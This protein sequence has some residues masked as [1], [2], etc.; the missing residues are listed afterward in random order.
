MPNPTPPSVIEICRKL[1]AIPSINPF[2]TQHMPD[3]Q[4]AIAGTEQ[5]IL[6]FCQAF[7]RQYGWSV[8]RQACGAGRENLIAEHGSGPQTCILYGH[9]DTVEVKEG[10]TRNEAL[11]PRL[12]QEYV[13]G[14]QESVLYGLGS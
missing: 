4:V 3:G 10:W 1:I 5:D 13:D 11:T 12:G 8:T 7:L 14:Q 6:D 2:Q 9:V